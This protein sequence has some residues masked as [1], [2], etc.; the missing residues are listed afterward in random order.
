LLSK[1]STTTIK[2]TSIKNIIKNIGLQDKE[3]AVYLACLK[4]GSS[5]ISAIAK[6]AKINR[7]TAYSTVEKLVEKGL[8]SQSKKKQ[9]AYFEAIAPDLIYKQLHEKL[10]TF[11]KALPELKKLH[12]KTE[13][14]LVRY[15]EG[16][17]GVKSIYMDTLTTKGELI[18]F[19]N[20]S[21]IRA[22][23]PEYDN[24]YVSSRVKKGI[25]LRGIAIDDET[26]RKV[27]SNDKK[28]H[29]KIKLVPASK[30]HFANEICIYDNRIAYASFG[31][32]P[33]GTIIEDEG[34]AETLKSIFEMMWKN[35]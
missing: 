1:V 6:E 14:P 16:V 15:F 21:E 3:A 13:H 17:E 11:K 26:G 28:F 7:V 35:Y 20:S 34:F 30:F 5:V 18:S 32:N 10:D 27:K 8:L 9:I 24:E 19:A 2:L 31:S 4:L 33:V 29:R 12:R 22:Y 23:W 25:F